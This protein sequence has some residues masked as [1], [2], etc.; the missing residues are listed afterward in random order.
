MN[1]S[2]DSARILQALAQ[3][4]MLSPQGHTDPVVNN[5]YADFLKTNPSVFL[6]DEEPLEA[7]Y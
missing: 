3:D 2:A 1:A 6:K 5:T 4:E 7:D